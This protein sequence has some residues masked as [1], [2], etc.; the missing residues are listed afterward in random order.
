MLYARYMDDAYIIEHD[1]N[2]LKVLLE[3]IEQLYSE[4]GIELNENK[5]QIIKITNGFTFCKTRYIL[6]DSGKVIMKPLREASI[7]VRHKLI[8]LHGLYEQGLITIQSAE[9]SYMSM[10]GNFLYR[11]AWHATHELD[12]LFYI[13][14]GFTPWKTANKRRKLKMKRGTTCKH[15]FRTNV[16]LTNATIYVSYMQNKSI[17][18]EKTNCDLI[19]Q[20][21]K[22]IVNLTQED[23]LSFKAGQT[24]SCQVRYILEDGTADA[25]NII[26]ISVQDVLKDGEINYIV[27]NANNSAGG[28]NNE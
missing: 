11:N 4:L 7:R 22:I 13:L 19:I 2:T 25:S 27:P 26:T 24:V 21:R 23:T 9:Q 18:I 16:D 6:T 12:K 28:E 3:I 10:R 8:K 5:T 1:K 15:T 20:Q 17:V 14:F